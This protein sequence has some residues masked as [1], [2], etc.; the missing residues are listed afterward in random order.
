LLSEWVSEQPNIALG[1]TKEGSLHIVQE[2]G[3]A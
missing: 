2:G 3:A 1:L